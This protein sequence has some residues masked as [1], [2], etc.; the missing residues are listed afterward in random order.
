MNLIQF[1]KILNQKLKY[2]I[3]LPVISAAI[4]MYT[5]RNLPV[6]YSTEATLFT[7]ITSNTGID[8]ENN[9]VDYFATQNEY[10]NILA[11][12]KS[13]TILEE[14]S[15]KLLAQH[16]LL[17]KPRKDIISEKAFKELHESVPPEV[18]KLIVKGNFEKSFQNLKHY[19]KQDD[20]N[21]IYGLLNYKNKYYST[22]ALSDIKSE[23]LTSSDLIKLSYESD[24]QGICYNSVK[25]LSLAFIEKYSGLKSNQ[26]G[27]AVAYFEKKLGESG[28]K[29]KI[30]ED[31]LLEFNT[32]NDIINYY[33][34][35]KHVSSQQQE[36]EVRQQEIKMEYLASQAVLA[37]I[38]AEIAKR[39]N[40]NLRSNEIL[41]IREQLI[42]T[43][44]DIAQ[45][46]LNPANS[47]STK[48]N[49]LKQKR[50]E[51]ESKLSTKIETIYNF[52]SNSQGIESQKILAEWLEAVKNFERNSALYKSMNQRRKEFMVQYQLYAP[53]GATLT[54]IQREIEVNEKEYLE[55]LHHLGLARL[56]QQ[57]AD[58]ISNMKVMDEPKLPIQAIPSKR[59]IFVI[60]AALFS[61]IFYIL[62]VFIIEL[63]D[64]RIKKPSI[65][66][67][68]SDL[69]VLGSF[70]LHDNKK[71]VNTE[72]VTERASLFLYEKIRLVA[73]A[74]NSPVTIQIFSNW[75]H[76]DNEYVSDIIK[77]ELEKHGYS[78][79][80]ISFL[81]STEINSLKIKDI[82]KTESYKQ[83]CNSIS[84]NT[85]FI[86][87]IF[88]PISEGID[89]PLLIKNGDI[90]ILV[91][92]A[93]A[94]WTNAD[95]FN[96]N[97][98]K[99]LVTTNL[100]AVLTKALPDNLDEMYGEIPKKRS[101]L[102]MYVKKIIQRFT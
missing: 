97:K 92:D 35:T 44:N 11:L 85:D 17:D 88:P 71:Y 87:S 66:K 77:N 46:E 26:T 61:V 98:L 99:Q 57:N 70:C 13:K 1:I 18:T 6:N 67:T 25:F 72:K 23:R 93:T 31:R 10:N 86:I 78:V 30:A 37:K 20:H 15:L 82:Y 34:Q 96:L 68:K 33:E 58:M 73:S 21:F 45:I 81:D 51:L 49:S 41:G 95:T 2:I 47:T 62:G 14:V 22:D 64:H 69:D 84:I 102:R 4:V 94:T 100:Y 9:R 32:K 48:L 7:G 54:R 59:K 76:S 89:N 91:F 90:S 53:L 60:L 83:L 28:D 50:K 36:I 39:Y 19:V 38:D 65:L 42:S 75:E 3:I 5:T 80:I 79:S 16:L 24:D 55:I 74:H 43:N 29:L 12:L 8:V 52:D 27:S 63:L 56:K 40:I 101:A